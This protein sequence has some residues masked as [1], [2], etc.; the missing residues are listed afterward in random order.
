MRLKRDF[1]RVAIANPKVRV[2]DCSFNAAQA[3]QAI[4]QATEQ[5]ASLVL[6]PELSISSVS[7]GDLL[8]DNLDRK[9][10]V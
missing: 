3:L 4:E 9:S 5:K 2:A 8:T 10:V 7:C 1:V 6:F